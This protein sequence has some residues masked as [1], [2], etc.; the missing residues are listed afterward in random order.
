MSGGDL[1][2]E[3]PGDELRDD[4]FPDEDDSQDESGQTI[5]CPECG[6]EIYE[7]AVMCPVCEV[8]VTQVNS[9]WSGRP[10]WWTVL[11]LL[12]MV[13]LVAVFLLL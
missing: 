1:W 13:A 4:E 11:G 7:E 5:L 2:F 10:L 3:R 8:F 12:G 6:A 9:P